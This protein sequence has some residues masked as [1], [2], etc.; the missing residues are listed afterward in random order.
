MSGSYILA[1][2][3]GTTSSRAM[4]FDRVGRA[5]GQLNRTFRQIYPQPGWVEHDPSE[6]WNT[7]IGAAR[8]LMAQKGVAPAE[9]A[10]I[11]ITNQR[12]TTILWDRATGEPVHNAIV[13]QCR[14][15]AGYCDELKARGWSSPITP[16][17]RGALLGVFTQARQTVEGAIEAV[18]ANKAGSQ[19]ALDKAAK[20]IDASLQ[21]YNATVGK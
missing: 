18:L 20:T 2:D 12:E 15:T 13:W 4:L 6:I 1:L 17:T 10:A 9:I 14:R 21:Q 7:Q 11:G 19:D 3:Q 8:E 16:A 5:L